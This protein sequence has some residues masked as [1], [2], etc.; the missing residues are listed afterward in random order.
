MKNREP[1]KLLDLGYY[2]VVRD[3]YIYTPYNNNFTSHVV[4]NTL[5]LPVG[6]VFRVSKIHLSIHKNDYNLIFNLSYNK[7]HKLPFTQYVHLHTGEQRR[8]NNHISDHVIVLDS[9]DLAMCKSRK[10]EFLQ[11]LESEGLTFG[12]FNVK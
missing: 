4:P 11:E 12:P 3:L 2:I 7:E 5:H 1:N 6:T 10:L 9:D 8:Q